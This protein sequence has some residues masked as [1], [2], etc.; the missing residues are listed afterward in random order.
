MPD[1]SKHQLRD[2]VMICGEYR[3]LVVGRAEHL[4][5]ED[6]YLVRWTDPAGPHEAWWGESALESAPAE[7]VPA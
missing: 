5:R 3:G 4:H 2:H 7:E 6:E 1:G